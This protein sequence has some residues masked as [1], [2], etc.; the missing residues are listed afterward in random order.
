MSQSLNPKLPKLPQPYPGATSGRKL[1]IGTSFGIG[2]PLDRRITES[3][4][5]RAYSCQV[6][7]HGYLNPTVNPK[8]SP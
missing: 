7:R 5:P 1:L 4:M 3:L 8:A 6:K 2:L